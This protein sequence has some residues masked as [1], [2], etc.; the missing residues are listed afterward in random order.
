MKFYRGFTLIELLVVIAIIGLLSSVVLASL[1]S[2]R[3]KSRD[4]KRLSDMKQIQMA[5]EFYKDSKGKYPGPVEN[6][7]LYGGFSEVN[8]YYTTRGSWDTS[9]HDAG[10]DG[11]PFIPLLE[12]EGYMKKVPTDP[13]DKPGVFG[14]Y[15]YYYYPNNTPMYGCDVSRG[16]YYVLGIVDMETV[17]TGKYHQSSPGWSCSGRNWAD[18]SKEWVSGSYEN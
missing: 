17:D 11:H 1:S 14:N 2:A 5:L 8:E 16:G 6:A 4:A 18:T 13:L 12:I 3:A 9:S 15:V 10:D 7:S